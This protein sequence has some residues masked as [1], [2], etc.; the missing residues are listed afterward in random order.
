M[1]DPQ[2]QPHILSGPL[3]SLLAPALEQTGYREGCPS[4]VSLYVCFHIG[5]GTEYAV[6]FLFSHSSHSRGLKAADSTVLMKVSMVTHNLPPPPSWVL[7]LPRLESLVINKLIMSVRS[8]HTCD[9]RC[10]SW[11]G[12]K[13]FF[14]FFFLGLHP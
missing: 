14:F 1:C 8:P 11:G 12:G 2:S 6:A 3:P 13:L 7:P 10:P 9:P 5:S 4:S